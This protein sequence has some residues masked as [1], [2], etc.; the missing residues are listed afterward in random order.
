M[1]NL[2]KTQRRKNMQNIHSAG[3]LPE[4]LIMCALRRKKIYF[5]KNVKSVTGKPDVVFRR[6]KIAVFVDSDFWHVHPKRFI[7]PQSNKHYWKEKVRRNKERD[8]EVNEK[9]RKE[10]WKVIRIWEHDI[11]RNTDKC[12]NKILKIVTQN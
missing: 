12:M 3:T 5:A 10:G 4:A 8:K 2:T 11:K 7:M 6:K 9:L 1:D